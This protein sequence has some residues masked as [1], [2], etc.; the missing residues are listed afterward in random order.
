MSLMKVLPR[1][2]CHKHVWA[3]KILEVIPKGNPDPSGQSAAASYGATIIPDDPSHGPF[4]VTADY[5]TKHNP[6]PGGYFVVYTDGYLSYSPAKAFEEGYSP[7]GNMSFGVALE[8]LKS[9][10]RVS[11]AGW[12]GK[13]MWLCLVARWSG[14]IGEMPVDYHL[15]PWIAM[16]TVDGGVVPWLASQTDVL[17]EDWALYNENGE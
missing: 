12:N 6:Q 4:P 14:A 10:K 1:Y 5:V 3:L 17:A 9:G 7:V 13:G 8:A 15:L 11:R 2:Q 16:K